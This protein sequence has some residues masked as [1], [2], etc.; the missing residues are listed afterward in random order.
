MNPSAGNALLKVLEEPPDNTVLILTAMQTSDLLPTIVSRCQHIR[1]NPIPRKHL[2]ALL[3]EKR[4]THPDDAKIIATLANGSFSKA[5]S[6]TSKKNPINWINRR[7][8]LIDEVQ[9]QSRRPMAARLA[10]AARL[11]KDKEVL[12]DSLEVLKTW[13]RD[14]VVW[15][16]HSGRILNTD[17][18]SKIQQASQ[19]MTVASILSKIN[20]IHVAQKNIEANTNLRLTLEVLIMR[21]VKV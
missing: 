17:L 9:S 15:K 6:M 16:Y 1:F 3:V 13:F 7:I 12:G 10:F 20:N 4:G 18:R 8:W 19:N 21:L 11:A 2:E 5:F 14:L